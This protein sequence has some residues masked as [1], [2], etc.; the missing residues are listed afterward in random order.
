MKIN[1]GLIYIT[2]YDK[3][4]F[5]NATDLQDFIGQIFSLDIVFNSIKSP[6]LMSNMVKCFY[7][8]TKKYIE[9]G[10]W[11]KENERINF[12]YYDLHSL[13]IGQTIDLF[14][15]NIELY[16]NFINLIELM[17][18]IN[19]FEIKNI[20]QKEGFYY[21][22]FLFKYTFLYLFVYIISFFNFNNLELTK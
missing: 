2:I 18:N 21:N 11:R 19:I 6:K 3:I 9:K 15:N 14:S 22:L 1:I 20:F 12:F 7:N 17:N 16:E 8:Y 10:H 4:L 13:L 5:N